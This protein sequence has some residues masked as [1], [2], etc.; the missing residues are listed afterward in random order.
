[1]TKFRPCIALHPGRVKQII[2]DSLR[3]G[4]HVIKL[5]PGNDSA[6]RECDLP[7]G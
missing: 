1:M 4:G 3:E 2:V 6:A 5:R 7:E